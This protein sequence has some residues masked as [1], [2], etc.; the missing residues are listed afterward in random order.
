MNERLAIIFF[1]LAFM[2][3]A[4]AFVLYAYLFASKKQLLGTLA[5]VFAVAGLL[6]HTVSLVARWRSIGY[7]PLEGAFESYFLFAWALAL[8]YLMV[9]RLTN[10]RIMGAVV[11]PFILVL[12]GIAWKRYESVARLD[13]VVKSSWIVMHVSLVFLAYAGFALAAIAAVFYLAQERQLK[14]RSTSIVFR[15]LP[16]LQTLD[17]LA[18]RAVIVAQIFMTM[19]IITGIIKAVK[20][21]PHWYVDGIVISTTISW[22]IYDL[23]LAARYV[24]EWRGRRVA[25]LSLVGF[26]LILLIAF[27]VKWFPTAF[28]SKFA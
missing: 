22:V 15:R 28:H 8:V 20:D 11:M 25:Y 2:M 5:T 18:M 7:L 26:V 1:W 14:N 17:N 13:P 19:T 3:Y 10:L 4:G 24:W 23:V 27:V 21:V 6:L 9:E 12:M 16:S